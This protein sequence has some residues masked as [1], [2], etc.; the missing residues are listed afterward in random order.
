M[1]WKISRRITS[2]AWHMNEKVRNNISN[3][4]VSSWVILCFVLTSVQEN[5]R[6]DFKLLVCPDE[7]N[8]GA[9]E[10]NA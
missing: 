2:T 3:L 10:G 1:C 4:Q 6:L 7:I 5:D 8:V 9:F